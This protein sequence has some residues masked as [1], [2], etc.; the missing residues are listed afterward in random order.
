[1]LVWLAD[2]LRAEG[3]DVDEIDG[4]G[5]NGD[6]DFDDIWGIICHHT[7]GDDISAATIARG[8]RERPG[9]LSN[10]LINRDGTV[11][12][13]AAGV[14][15]HAGRGYHP[16]LPHSDVDI[17]TVGVHAEL[18]GHQKYP[19]EQYL[20]YVRCCAAIL[21]HLNRSVAH[22]LGHQEWDSGK[23]DPCLSMDQL[24]A[25]IAAHLSAYPQPDSEAA[26]RSS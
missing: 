11:V 3:L 7:G 6:G 10:V 24:R 13:V 25:D 5:A 22:V 9:P 17:R 4:W 23:L 1:M 20:S 19:R 15:H 26:P 12:V 21:R 16:D 2:A 18:R 8:T 14:A